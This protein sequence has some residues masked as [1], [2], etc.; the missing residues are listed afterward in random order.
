RRE[1]FHRDPYSSDRQAG[2]PYPRDRYPDDPYRQ[3]PWADDPYDQDPADDHDTRPDTRPT[4]APAGPERHQKTTWWTLLPPALPRA[5]LCL[6]RLPGRPRLVAALGVG[7]AAALTGLS[8]G[9]L[10]GA[11]TAAAGAAVLLTSLSDGFSEGVADLAS[12]L[13]R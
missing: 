5:G 10:A 2:S 4:P 8:A 12:S 13:E 7:V 1:P 6:R 11:V 3:D 9:T